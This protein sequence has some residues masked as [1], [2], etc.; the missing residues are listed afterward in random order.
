MSH[1]L[2][3]KYGNIYNVLYAWLT[4]EQAESRIANDIL[5]GQFV[6]YPRVQLASSSL[7]H[8]Q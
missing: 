1:K 5:R 6:A 3:Y 4:Q 8:K 2:I 7:A